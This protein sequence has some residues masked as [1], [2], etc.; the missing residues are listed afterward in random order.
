MI[1]EAND[2]RLVLFATMMATPVV[3]T[4]RPRAALRRVMLSAMFAPLPRLTML[5]GFSRLVML[6]GLPRLAMLTSV[7]RLMRRFAAIAFPR[8]AAASYAAAMATL[9]FV[10]ERCFEWSAAG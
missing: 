2:R 4:L 8:V 7:A 1:A 5:A 3:A 9:A 6:A 10:V